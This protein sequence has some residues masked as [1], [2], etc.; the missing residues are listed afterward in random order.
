MCWDLS[1]LILLN[2]YYIKKKVNSRVRVQLSPLPMDQ[3]NIHLD[4]INDPYFLKQKCE[5]LNN[6]THNLTPTPPL[7]MKLCSLQWSFNGEIS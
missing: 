4:L 6:F 7:S 3:K 2:I 5:Y 1:Y